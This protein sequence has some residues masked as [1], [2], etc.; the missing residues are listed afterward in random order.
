MANDKIQVA[1]LANWPGANLSLQDDDVSQ[2]CD[3]FMTDWDTSSDIDNDY[4][5]GGVYWSPA[6]IAAAASA[7]QLTD[8]A[9]K[10]P[11]RIAIL[12]I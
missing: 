11:K 4:G 5:G 12:Y 3:H 9:T 2:N 10:R 6:E 8:D 1:T 7:R